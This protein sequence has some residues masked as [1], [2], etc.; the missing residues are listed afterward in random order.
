MTDPTTPATAPPTPSLSTPEQL[1][2]T[3]Q[4]G[5]QVFA[6]FVEVQKAKYGDDWKDQLSAEMAERMEPVMKAFLP[7]KKGP[8]ADPQN[9]K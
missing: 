2:Q 8:A 6:R 5:Q 4:F 1:E 7:A 3:R 9:D